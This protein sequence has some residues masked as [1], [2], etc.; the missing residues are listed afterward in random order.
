MILYLLENKMG[1]WYVLEDDP[2]SAKNF[3]EEAFADEGYG[4]EKREVKKIT[5]LAKE[6]TPAKG[7]TWSS[8]GEGNMFIP[9][10]MKEKGQRE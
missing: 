6:V 7:I 4:H 5:Q 9:E 2:T 10:R 8:K 1:N 3:L